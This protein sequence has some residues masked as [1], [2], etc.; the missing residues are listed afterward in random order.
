MTAPRK[1]VLSPETRAILAHLRTHAQRTFPQLLSELPHRHAPHGL[2]SRLRALVDGTW[3][4]CSYPSCDAESE[5]CWSIHPFARGAVAL[6]LD[7]PPE[8]STLVPPRTNNIMA[9]TYTYQPMHAV[10][11]GALDHAAVA[12][13]GQHC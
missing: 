9:G 10:R 4:V 8:R 5:V 13:R 12:S 11:A 1:A 7:P 2:R 3:L 6:A